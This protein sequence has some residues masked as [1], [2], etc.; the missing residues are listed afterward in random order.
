MSQLHL[1]SGHAARFAH[2]N[3]PIGQLRIP[4]SRKATWPIGKEETIMRNF[5]VF[6]LG[7]LIGRMF[8][9]GCLLALPRKEPEERAKNER[10]APHLFRVR[11]FQHFFR[12]G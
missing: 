2:Q 9:E 1:T 8:I 5:K 6:Q 4:T 12:F 7:Y 11:V 10:S 3:Y